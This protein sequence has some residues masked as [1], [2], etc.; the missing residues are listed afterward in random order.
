ML[1]V[2]LPLA[3]SVYYWQKMDDRL[4]LIFWIALASAISDAISYTLFLL[5]RP[6]WAVGNVFLII[7]FILFYL[8][9][10]VRRPIVL[11]FFFYATVLFGIINFFFIQEPNTFNSYTS[12]VVALLM[13]VTALFYLYQLLENLPT[14]KIQHLPLFWVAFG[15]LIYYGGTLFLFLFSNYVLAGSK[16]NHQTIWILHNVINIIK[17]IFLFIAIWFSHKRQ[18]SS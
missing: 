3:A 16:E 14:E 7:Q 17:N 1:S 8:I 12:Y 9:L 15:A 10:T 4:R 13:I 5:A 18:T 2:V 6:N 11:R